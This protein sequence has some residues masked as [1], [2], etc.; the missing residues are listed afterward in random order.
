MTAAANVITTTTS[1]A[2]HHDDSTAADGSMILDAHVT[3]AAAAAVVNNMTSAAASINN[4][5]NMES[6][7]GI[8]DLLDNFN[9]EEMLS[10]YGAAAAHA[11]AARR[12]SLEEMLSVGAFNGAINGA[13]PTAM[14]HH[15]HHHQLT[16]HLST[17][18]ALTGHVVAGEGVDTH[19]RNVS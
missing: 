9:I 11:H 2:S 13:M 15:H 8:T 17:M 5:N 4:N 18:P 19:M 3:S 6:L 16:Q 12:N 14:S 7:D 1:T 10:S